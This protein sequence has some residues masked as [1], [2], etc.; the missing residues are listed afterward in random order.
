[1]PR[2][3]PPVKP[4]SPEKAAAREA[5][6]RATRAAKALDSERRGYLTILKCSHVTKFVP[7]PRVYDTVF[8]RKCDDYTVVV[9]LVPLARRASESAESQQP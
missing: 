7:E 1:M 2:S 6:T 4:W 5:K 3:I 8:C 9:G